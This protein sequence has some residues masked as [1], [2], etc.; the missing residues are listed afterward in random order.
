MSKVIKTS[1]TGIFVLLLALTLE[2]KP[3]WAEELTISGNGEGSQNTVSVSTNTTTS[4]EQSNNT[5]VGSD[6]DLN[7]D[8]G[9][10]QASDNSGSTAI[11]TRDTTEQST[12]ENSANSSEVTSNCCVTAASQ[13]AISGNG[14]DS[15]NSIATNQTNQIEIT[16]SQTANISN[17]IEGQANT[18][19]NEA[20]SNGG[21]VSIET[22]NINA[23]ENIQ[24]SDINL[25]SISAPQGG[26]SSWS[27]SIFNNGS[28]SINSINIDLI[29]QNSIIINNEANIE[30]NSH[31]DL[32][33]G[34]NFANGNLGD[35]AITTGDID[36][37][38]AIEN[39]FINIS[40]VALICCAAPTPT[41]SPSP[42][43]SPTPNPSP[44]EEEDGEGDPSGENDGT[45]SVSVGGGGA[46]TSGG[47]DAQETAGEV[48][49]AAALGEALAAAGNNWLIILTLLGLL[50]L[51]SGLYLRF[52]PQP[53]ASIKRLIFAM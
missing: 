12:I 20:S 46:G 17:T 26:S 21:N 25:S 42:S 22:G 41:P 29:N 27:A 50:S 7:A 14:S 15:T 51:G 24:N 6:V 19:S 34:G 16:V 18:G 8:T 3:V 49:G 43:S 28:D 23:E 48:L 1:T 36:F 33:T 35:I 9:N 44:S 39:A 10:N 32:N 40:E 4:I 38:S 47:P 5:Q 13:A 11:T 2:L 45:R 31:W 30:N 53:Q 52:G 37:N